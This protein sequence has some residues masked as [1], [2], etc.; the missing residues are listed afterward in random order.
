[1]IGRGFP[2]R[3]ETQM[4]NE[5]TARDALPEDQPTEKDVPPPPSENVGHG[6]G[7]SAWG[8]GDREGRRG[9]GVRG[10]GRLPPETPSV[11]SRI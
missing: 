9:R 8:T 2:V 10:S 3:Q 5:I 4:M 7:E 6:P 11:T 1:M